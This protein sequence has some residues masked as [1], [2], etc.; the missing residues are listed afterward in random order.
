M[1]LNEL[2]AAAALEDACVAATD[3][4][5]EATNDQRER[6]AL[7][8]RMICGCLISIMAEADY[9]TRVSIAERLNAELPGGWCL[10]D[11]P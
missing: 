9:A 5:D 11:D 6:D 10:A 4:I 8:Q 2:D 1:P 7:W 3:V